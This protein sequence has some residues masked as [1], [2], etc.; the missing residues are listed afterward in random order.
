MLKGRNAVVTGASRGIGKAVCIEL[1]K[2]GANVIVNYVGNKQLAQETVDECIKYNVKA[3]AI[4][5]NISIASEAKMLIDTCVKEFGT[6]DILVNNA[7]IC[8]DNLLLRMTEQDFEDVIDTNLKGA[9]LCSK[10]AC[11]PMMKQRFGRIV[12]LGSVVG[13]SGNAGQVNYSASK[14]GLVGLSKSLAKELA[15]KNVT[16][17]VVAPGFI[18]TDMS[19][20]IPEKMKEKILAE[21]PLGTLGN[22]EDVANA[23]VFF[24]LPQSKY[25]T[26]QVLHVDGGMAM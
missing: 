26:G 5:A 8:K 21:I 11:R 22:V 2:Q 25:I 12:N 16:V 3:I 24:T 18:D 6:I 20:A 9:F 15:S 17:N 4:Q 19:A 14:A 10:F 23:I 1:A 7:G 13:T